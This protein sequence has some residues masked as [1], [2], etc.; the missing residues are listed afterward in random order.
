MLT[1]FISDVALVERF[2]TWHD[3]YSLPV[4]YA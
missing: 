4:N 1:S 3:Y 2:D